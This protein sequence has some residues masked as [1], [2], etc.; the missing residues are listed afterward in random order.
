MHFLAISC[1]YVHGNTSVQHIAQKS[2]VSKILNSDILEIRTGRTFRV[3][4]GL[5][6]G[7]L[8]LDDQIGAERTVLLF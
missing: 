4:E 1:A 2:S 8:F 6:P 7:V 5:V 3:E